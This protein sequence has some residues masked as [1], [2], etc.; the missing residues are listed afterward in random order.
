[1]DIPFA[2][3]RTVLAA[4]LPDYPI[5]VT[6]VLGEGLDNVA[7]E[8]NG[9]PVLRVGKNPDPVARQVR[10]AREAALLAAVAPF[11]P[12]PIPEPAF[13]TDG[14]L[15]YRTMPGVPLLELP[16]R[17]RRANVRPIAGVLGDFLAALHAIPADLV[18]AW[19]EADVEPFAEW[20]VEATE[21]YAAVI[22]EVPHE[23]R[24]GIERFLRS[25]APGEPAE[26]EMVFSHNDLGIE[27]VLVDRTSVGVLGVIDWSDA[28]FVDPATDFGL[29]LR[30]LGPAALG[31]AVGRHPHASSA[32]A[33]RAGFY[34]RCS[35]LEDLR[36]G[37]ENDRPGYVD[38]SIDSLSWLFRGLS[39]PLGR[40][41]DSASPPLGRASPRGSTSAARTNSA[42]LG[43]V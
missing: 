33:E 29:I 10:A 9:E 18:A 12:L 26:H 6:T 28:A 38:K 40:P 32:L 1:M 13:A 14:M 37:V 23:H 36:Y 19:V 34:A 21:C 42:L 35:V 27:H 31:V 25:A 22:G 15:A 2:D 5:Q 11:A 20:L 3:I 30:D 43:R 17:W 16:R 24:A 8:V 7:Y 41:L 39:T 4:R